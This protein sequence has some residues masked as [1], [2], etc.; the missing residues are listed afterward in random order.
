MATEVDAAAAGIQVEAPSD[1]DTLALDG[2][3]PAYRP[4]P[5]EVEHITAEWLTEALS[6]R[7]PGL[8]V[9]G[10]EITEV[11]HGFTSLI[12][13]T[14]DLN[15]AGREAGV[16]ETVVIKGGFTQHS[17]HYFFGYGMEAQSYRDIWPELGLNIPRA[18]FVDIDIASQ[19][20]IIVMENLNARGVEFTSVYEPLNYDQ[21]RRRLTALAQV[22]AKSW[23]SPHFK[24]GGKWSS[25]LANGIRLQRLN[26]EASG[27]ILSDPAQSQPEDFV[28]APPFL[29]PDGWAE[30]WKLPQNA[31]VPMQH[32]DLDWN[33]RSI[34]YLEALS[35]RLPNCIVHGDMHLHNQYDEPDGTPGYFDM[36]PRREPP[37]FEVCYTIT[38]DL[39]PV[40]RR[41]WERSLVGHYVDELARHGIEQDFD[42]AMYYYAILLHQGHIWFVV[43]DPVWQP[44]RFNTANN[45]RFQ[46]AMVDNDT[47]GLLDAAFVGHVPPGAVAAFG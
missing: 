32:R 36:M 33:R 35:D 43:N 22:H 24:P 42:L 12:F 29:T 34:E 19:Q 6:S 4:L 25:V 47:K 18:Y 1:W 2:E 8:A 41:N 40:D 17:R 30:I 28:Q 20:S 9:K 10:F 23:D 37:F 7:A 39:D 38:C 21:I 16:P 14:L 44:V 27:L 13:V 46:A 26:M 31:L 11:R 3:L 45:A 5:T 15:D